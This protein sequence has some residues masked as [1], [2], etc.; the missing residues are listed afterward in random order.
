MNQHYIKKAELVNNRPYYTG[1]DKEHAIWFDGTGNW[2][3]G[4]ISSIRLNHLT[5]GHIINTNY[6]DCPVSAELFYGKSGIR[7]QGKL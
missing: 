4:D 2:L 7:C 3:V 5:S 6:K 1:L